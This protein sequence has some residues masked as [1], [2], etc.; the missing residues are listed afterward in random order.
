M[1]FERVI[2]HN[3][4]STQK[5]RKEETLHKFPRVLYFRNPK[6]RET[7]VAHVKRWGNK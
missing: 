4:G 1:G 5:K 6:K 2:F 7:F 3:Q